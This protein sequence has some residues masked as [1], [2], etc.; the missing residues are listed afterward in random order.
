MLNIS[1]LLSGKSV[2]TWTSTPHFLTNWWY[3]PYGLFQVLRMS[4]PQS[5]KLSQKNFHFPCF[6]YM[7]PRLSA[8]STEGWLM[9]FHFSKWLSFEHAQWALLNELNEHCSWLLPHKQAICFNSLI[10]LSG[11]KS[12]QKSLFSLCTSRKRVKAFCFHFSLLE[13]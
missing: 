10:W 3:F 9:N 12:V 7:L 13:L 5:K 2:N 6:Q 1:C 11:N 8:Y 4:W